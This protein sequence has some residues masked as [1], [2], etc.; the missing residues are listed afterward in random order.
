[1]K[2]GPGLKAAVTSVIAAHRLSNKAYLVFI[3]L[4]GKD[5]HKYGSSLGIRAVL[6]SG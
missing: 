1:M 2:S 3:M 6:G 4:L 5:L